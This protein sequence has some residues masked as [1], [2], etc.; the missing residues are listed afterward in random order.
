MRNCPDIFPKCLL[1]FVFPPVIYVGFNFCISS[2]TLVIH[3]FDYC[4]PSGREVVS[5]GGFNLHFPNG[6]FS[7][8]HCL[9]VYLLEKYL[10]RSFAFLKI[11][12]C[13]NCYS[14]RVL[15]IFQ[16]VSAY[17]INVLEKFLILFSHSVVGFFFFL[18]ARW[19]LRNRKF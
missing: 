19:C 2:L 7:C 15:Y 17:Q 6:I 13:F 11:Q 3:F 9:F 16:I 4:H 10:F 8:K 14:I 5:C 18:L 12:L 1:Y